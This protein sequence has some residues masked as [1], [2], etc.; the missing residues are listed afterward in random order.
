MEF[1]FKISDE[2]HIGI[3]VPTVIGWLPV[4]VFGDWESYSDFMKLMAS[5]YNAHH[6]EIPDAYRGVF[7]GENQ[8]N[9]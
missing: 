2:G 8:K 3:F 5:F 9:H 7:G 4:L 6:T 1:K